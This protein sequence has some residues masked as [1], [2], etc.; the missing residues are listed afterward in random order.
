LETTALLTAT[1]RPVLALLLALS[2]P[3]IAAT[4]NELARAIRKCQAPD[5]AIAMEPGSD[6]VIPYFANLAALGLVAA[7]DAPNAARWADWYRARMQ[8]NGVVDDYTGRSGAWKSAKKRDSTDSYAATW[9]ELMD[10]LAS[11]RSDAWLR[12]R[13]VNVRLAVAAIRLTLQPVG[14]TL[15]KPDW[16]VMYTMDNTETARGLRA[17]ARLAKRAGDAASAR[18]WNAMA[19]RMETAVREKLWDVNRKCYL[20]GLQPDGG[21]MDG[22]SKWYPDVMANLMAIGW[23]PAS[24][25]NRALFARL[26]TQFGAEIPAAARTADDVDRLAWWALAARGA[27]DAPRT[28]LLLARLAAFDLARTPLDNP[29]LLGHLCRLTAA[30]GVA[31]P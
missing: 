13:Y 5:G 19:A 29:A 26:W 4:P 15:A 6:T 27:G 2:L 24:E 1:V 9:L 25:R 3:A 12:A 10:A 16:P 31:N 14:L 7:G 11:G 28:R 17:A 8:P 18:E 23:G 30:K 22:L 20:V 21:R